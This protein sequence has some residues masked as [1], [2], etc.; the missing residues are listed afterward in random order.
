MHRNRSSTKSV[1]A[2]RRR[3]ASQQ[4]VDGRCHVT[5]P[6][7]RCPRDAIS[8]NPKVVVG[9]AKP[10]YLLTNIVPLPTIN[11]D[12]IWGFGGPKACMVMVLMH[13]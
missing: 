5:E 4:V 8:L 12:E 3:V 2:V 6:A 10:S 1:V 7:A 11:V 9:I 13:I